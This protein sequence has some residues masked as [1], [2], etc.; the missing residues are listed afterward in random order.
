MSAPLTDATAQPPLAVN[1]YLTD[2]ARF[3][4][5]EMATS[6]Y[7]GH[8]SVVTGKWPNQLARE[9][10]Y[11]SFLTT[12]R[13]RATVATSPFAIPRLR[14]EPEWGIGELRYALGR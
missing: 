14:L 1:P 11:H 5:Q 13:G 12:I 2:S 7:F 4:A 10:G 9:A 3:H 6:N 8:Q